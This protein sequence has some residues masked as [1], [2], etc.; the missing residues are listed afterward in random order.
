MGKNKNANFSKRA[1]CPISKFCVVIREVILQ[2]MAPFL[3]LINFFSV[4]TLLA[5]CDEAIL[6]VE[7]T[8]HNQTFPLEELFC[9]YSH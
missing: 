3:D 5:D 9:D 2:K 8:T 4:L 1:R 6:T 7:L